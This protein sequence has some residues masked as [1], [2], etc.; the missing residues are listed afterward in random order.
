MQGK[1][2]EHILRKSTIRN[3]I[4]ALKQKHG[5]QKR[6]KKKITVRRL[7]EKSKLSST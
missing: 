6:K 5:V 1:I 4:V 7:P 2:H 3:G